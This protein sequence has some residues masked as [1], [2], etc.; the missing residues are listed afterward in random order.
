MYRIA[1]TRKVVSFEFDHWIYKVVKEIPPFKTRGLAEVKAA[2]MN[3]AEKRI[4]HDPW[5]WYY[6][7]IEDN[8]RTK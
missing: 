5:N 1:V 4:D 8:E 3:E 7:V 6:S 2:R